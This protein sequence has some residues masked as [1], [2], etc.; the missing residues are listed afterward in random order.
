[1]HDVPVTRL[2]TKHAYRGH[3]FI[4]K[5]AHSARRGL[6]CSGRSQM[7]ANVEVVIECSGQTSNTPGLPRLLFQLT[8]REGRLSANPSSL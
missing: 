4:K 2:N 3:D 6:F 7:R 8:V 5:P 1:V